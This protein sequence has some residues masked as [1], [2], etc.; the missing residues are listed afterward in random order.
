MQNNSFSVFEYLM[1]NLVYQESI[2]WEIIYYFS[3]VD[4]K[5]MELWTLWSI[6]ILLYE[7]MWFH[8]LELLEAK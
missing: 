6:I 1:A 8:K 4:E 7:K 2:P 3:D 5:K